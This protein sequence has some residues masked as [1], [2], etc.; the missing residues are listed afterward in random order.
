MSIFLVTVITCSQASGLLDRLLS[1]R[2]ITEE[3]RRE[4]I[5]EIRKVIPSC[6]V[7]V[8]QK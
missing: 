8:N 4:I 2:N 5:I 3:Q 1:V 6:P 7:K